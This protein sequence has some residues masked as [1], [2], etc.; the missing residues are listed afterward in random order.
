MVMRGVN[1]GFFGSPP[2]AAACLDELLRAFKVTL[3]VTKPDKEVGRGR[4]VHQTP[5]SA[6]A[7]KADIQII[8]PHTI[9]R[10]LL[11]TMKEMEV[12]LIVVVAFGKILPELVLGYPKFGC[13]NLHASLLPKYRGPSPIQA[14]L[15]N[16]DRI[17]G[18]TVQ[19]M[20]SR[21]DAGDII[22]SQPLK[23]GLNMT[24]EDLMN[25]FIQRAPGFLTRS[26][27]GYLKGELQ[28]QP[29][30]EH[31]ATYCTKI[32][33][34]DGFIDWNGSTESI[35]NK[36]RALSIWPV[37]STFIDGRLLRIFNVHIPPIE[38][39]DSSEP[40][41]VVD[42][43]RRQGIIVKT[44]DGILGIL[45]LQLENKRRMS[46]KEFM[47]GYRN[48]KGKVLGEGHNLIKS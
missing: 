46:F 7:Q 28:P 34:G 8:K 5:V 32:Q 41:T 11:H 38:L 30:D 45:E 20:E 35:L 10:D 42:L 40:G 23:V 6:V 47:N 27:K 22:S 36:V 13:L 39:V 9:D 33:K 25:I 24:A 3:V 4:K 2:L 31:E 17:T 21:M 12:A 48:L 1:I 16:G 44:G 18:M 19:L 14:A 37:A 43:D 26:V 15:L 29:Q